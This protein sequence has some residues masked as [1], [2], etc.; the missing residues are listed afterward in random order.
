MSPLNVKL[1][2]SISTSFP[3][4]CSY[5]CSFPSLTFVHHQC[6]FHQY[7]VSSI[8]PEKIS[9]QVYICIYSVFLIYQQICQPIIV[10]ESFSF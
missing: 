7:P 9:Q 6:Q 4:I 3:L 8:P 10:S 2:R 5:Y 1:F